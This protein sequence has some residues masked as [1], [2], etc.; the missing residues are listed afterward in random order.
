MKTN[1]KSTKQ[2]KAIIAAVVAVV[3]LGVGITIA[4]N[5]DLISFNNLFTLPA[6]IGAEFIETFESPSNWMPG[7]VTPLEAIAKNKTDDTAYVR[8]KI[9][10]Y[11]RTADSQT[12]P[13]DHT[14]SDLPLT[15]TDTNSQV[16]EYATITY[17][18]LSDWELR[19]D[20]WY[21]YKTALATDAVTSSMLE[22]VTFN[23][24]I[25]LA[26]GM[27]YSNDGHTATTVMSDYANATF[28][29]Y[30]TFQL[31]RSFN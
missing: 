16:H 22:S 8:M 18:N 29:V 13:D 5:R 7:D 14:T 10:Q 12:S 15:W 21:Y 31:A 6:D 19:A 26:N 28:H 4:F 23:D 2:K 27:S 30:I 25:N 17:K 9:N 20:G 24:G 11:W 1:L 3:A